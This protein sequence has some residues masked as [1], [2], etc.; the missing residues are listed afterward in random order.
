MINLFYTR[1]AAI[2]SHRTAVIP[3]LNT[4]PVEDSTKKQLRQQIEMIS[5]NHNDR[6]KAI[7]VGCYSC[8]CVCIHI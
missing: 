5:P 3:K 2:D 1:L 4:L 7:E 6:V 8:E